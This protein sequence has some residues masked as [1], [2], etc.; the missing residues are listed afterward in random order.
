MTLVFR[1]HHFSR[2]SFADYGIAKTKDFPIA[3][4]S[5]TVKPLPH[6]GFTMVSCGTAVKPLQYKG[7]RNDH[8]QYIG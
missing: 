2:Y 1:I 5:H 6:K 3:L 8:Q 7:N 4:K